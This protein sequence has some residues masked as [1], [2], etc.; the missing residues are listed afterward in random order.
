MASFG[1]LQR[2]AQLPLVE[3]RPGCSGRCVP[4]VHRYR[5]GACGGLTTTER[6]RGSQQPRQAAS[7]DMVRF[8]EPNNTRGSRKAAAGPAVDKV[9]VLLLNLGGPETLSDVKPF[10]YNLFADPDI[11]RLPQVVQFLQP[12]LAMVIST[13]RA[14]KSAEGYKAIGGGSPLRKI[15]DEQAEALSVA[16]AAKGQAANVYVGM[17]YWHPYTEEALA[18]I[19]RDGVTRLVILPLYP[20]FSI[21]TS[22]SSLRLLESLFKSDRALKQLRHTVI[23]SWYQRRGYVCAMADLIV[24]ELVKF[25]DVAGVE[26]FFSAHGVPKSYVEE[27]GDPYK[28]EMEE[29]VRLIMQEVRQRGYQN[30]H[31]L[32][33][34]SRVGPAEWLKPYTDDSIRMLGRTGVKSM[35]AVPISF[36]SEHIETLEEIDMEYRELA[37]ESGIRHW[38]RVPALNTNAAFIEDLAEAVLEA[39]PYVGCLAGPTDSLVPLAALHPWPEPHLLHPHSRSHPRHPRLHPRLLH[40]PHPRLLHH[41]RRRPGGA[42]AGIRSGA[43]R[44]ALAGGDVGVGVDQERGD[45]ERAHRDAGDHC[46]SGAGGVERAVHS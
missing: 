37:H 39:L 40:H 45:V 46:H 38:G 42:A 19:K 29:C 17:R 31:T 4:V 41:P 5:R 26:V 7:T 24:Q 28:E 15:T 30:S 43:P 9:G 18:Q 23:P 6:R 32:A 36:V 12:V 11:I 21:S 34:Q 1:L 2:T 20:Q 33:Y 25:D 8:E 16:L 13:L 27:A 35:L 14:P 44:A 22:G 10:L 3:E